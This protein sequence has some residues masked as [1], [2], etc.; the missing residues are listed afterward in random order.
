MQFKTSVLNKVNKLKPTLQVLHQPLSQPATFLV[1][2][3]WLAGTPLDGICYDKH[4]L[5]TL[6]GMLHMPSVAIHIT[7][8]RKGHLAI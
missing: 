8:F 3:T 1:A 7:P 5:P 4:T 2:M 6:P